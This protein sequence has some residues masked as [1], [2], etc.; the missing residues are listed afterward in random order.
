MYN[1]HIVLQHY[2][3]KINI[4]KMHIMT[5]TLPTFTARCW[6]SSA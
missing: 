2:T 5:T 6:I 3:R 4:C 1:T